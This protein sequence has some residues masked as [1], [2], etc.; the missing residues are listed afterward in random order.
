MPTPSLLYYPDFYPNSVWLRALLLL[1][2]DVK[3]VVP[4]DVVPNDSED[5]KGLIGEIGVLDSVPPE[6]TQILPIGEDLAWLERSLELIGR[7]ARKKP[8]KKKIEILVGPSG[9]VEFPNHV[10]IYDKKLSKIVRDLLEKNELVDDKIQ[11]LASTIGDMHGKTVVNAHAS[12]TILSFIAG[13]IAKDTG[14]IATTDH[15]LGFA[16]N[17][18]RAQRVP[19]RAPKGSP[20]GMLTSAFASVLVPK[21]VGEVPLKEYLIL[22]KYSQDMRDAFGKF[23]VQCDEL[24]RLEQ[25]ENATALQ[26]KIEERAKKFD[27]EFKKFKKG[28]SKIV[29]AIRDW[30]PLTLGALFA[31]GKD[32][33]PPELALSFGALGQT[34]KFAEK[35]FVSSPDK[36]KEK[37]F[38]L[39]AELGT[40]IRALP[41]V[42][43]LLHG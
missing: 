40:N 36:R 6:E 29:R 20:E 13:S 26:S 10:V 15:S 24:A 34:A 8:N 14:L 32:F 4:K 11:K 28:R 12:T 16:M 19:I 22:R 5:L 1:V 3:R 21:E 7:D 30:W 31:L 9:E 33:V 2:D 39:A 23:M 41:R 25:I 35:V 18:L 38:S 43:E 37:V 42:S 27:A 17:A